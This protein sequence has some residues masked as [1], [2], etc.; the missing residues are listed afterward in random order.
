M[1]ARFVFSPLLSVFDYRQ[2]KSVPSLAVFSIALLIGLSNVSYAQQLP[3]NVPYVWDNFSGGLNTKLSEFSLDKR[4]CTIAENIRFNTELNSLSKRDQVLSYGSASGTEAITGLHRLY[5]KSGTKV[6]LTTHGDEL[7]KG[8][9]DAGTFTNIL[10]LDTG[11]YRWQWQTWHDIAIGT[12]G[13]NQPVKTDG[14][15]ATYLGTCFSE[16]ADSGSGPDGTYHYKVSY[17][18]A[19][20]E[21]TLSVASNA[22][23]V[24]DNDID[25]SMIPI[26]PDTYGGEDVVGRKI[27]RHKNGATVYYLLSNGTVANNTATT[28]TDSDADAGLSATVYPTGDSDYKPPL[29]KFVLVHK[30]RLWIG[31]DPSYPSRLYYSDDSSHDIF[32]TGDY[33]DIRPNDGDEITFV[34][35][36]L[37]ILTVGKSNTIQK[38]YTDGTDPDADW[39]ISDPFSFI[40][41]QAPYSADNSTIGI[42]YLARDGLYKFNGQYSNLISEAVT[43]VINDISQSNFTNCWG[44]FNN[45][46]Y[47]LAYASEESGASDNNRVLILDVLSN[48]YSIDPLAINVFTSFNSGS[49][50]GVVYSGSSTDGNIYSLSGA[51]HEIVHKKQSDF[52][53]TWD[54]MRYIPTRWGGDADSAVLEVAWDETIDQLTGTIDNLPGI[55]DRDTSGGSYISQFLNI[56]ASSFDKLYWNET[57]PSTGGDVTFNLR[58]GPT[59]PDC[60]AATWESLE[61]SDPTGSDVSAATAND[62]VQYRVTMTSDSITY[63]PTVYNAFNYAIKLTYNTE[64]TTSETTI[65]FRWES[66]W[67]DLGYPGRDKTLNTLFVYHDSPDQTGTLTL[68]FENFEGDTDEF[69]INLNN[70]PTHYVE[71]FTTGKFRGKL[72]KLKINESSLNPLTVKRVIVYYDVEP[73][74]D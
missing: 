10:N 11:D 6:L 31:N 23:T 67:T 56:G 63:S 15:D 66:G 71:Q 49:D 45:N 38:L 21:V 52:T 17:Y 18:T 74:I 30:N 48:A 13:Y 4:Q 59:S 33:F 14:T 70:N 55:V 60:L 39:E 9:D 65:P 69:E 57:I 19:S 53:G 46:I 1:K 2:K 25:L 50:W 20:Y 28:L 37:G 26:A 61:Y 43:P 58:S 41:C 35:N 42:I 73:F 8:D 7:E 54:S 40:G 12:D 44:E 36:L 22:V 32:I 24:S 68:T 34:L 51:T 5:L 64:G 29:G 72:F 3:T 62:F 47:R 27:Y 16:D